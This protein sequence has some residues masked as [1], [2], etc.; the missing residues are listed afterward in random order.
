LTG[1]RTRCGRRFAPIKVFGYSSVH[2]V[3][4]PTQMNYDVKSFHSCKFVPSSEKVNNS[5]SITSFD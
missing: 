2:A 5:I 3:G 4:P 1:A